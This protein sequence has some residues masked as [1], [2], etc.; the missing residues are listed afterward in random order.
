MLKRILDSEQYLRKQGIKSSDVL[1]VLGT[2]LSE[3]IGSIEI[4]NDIPYREIPHFPVSTVKSHRG[5]LIQGNMHKKTVTIL[6]GR[7]HYYEGYDMQTVVLPLRVLMRIGTRL[8]IVSNAAG[9]VNHDYFAGDI[10]LIKDHINM[11]PDNPLRGENLDELGERFPL[12][13]DAYSI[14]HRKTILS[15]AE[16]MNIK[17]HQ[18]V[19]LAWSGPSLETDAEYNMA[20]V[21]GADAVGMSTVPEVIAARHMGVDVA[22][23]SVI[24]NINNKNSRDDST[25]DDVIENAA[26]ASS[27]LRKIVE[28]FIKEVTL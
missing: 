16:G 25:H 3:L 12:M 24:T 15:I 5:S 1:I 21:V 2:G 9:G 8:L 28:Q 4:E 26:R 20:R 7:F 11:M 6:S 22:G 10:M 27:N 14:E 18:G 13:K 19:Y 23:F 17:L